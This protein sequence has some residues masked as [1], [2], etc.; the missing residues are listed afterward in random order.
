MRL[1]THSVFHEQRSGEQF[2]SENGISTV[3]ML[4]DK[5]EPAVM[6]FPC[7]KLRIL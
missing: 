7:S 5:V 6:S 2:M 3:T 4:Q 1:E